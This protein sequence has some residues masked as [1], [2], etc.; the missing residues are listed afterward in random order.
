VLRDADGPV[1]AGLLDAAWADERQR[2]RALA[3]LVADGLAEQV[4]GGG[5]ALPR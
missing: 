1:P 3:S 2:V 5:Y 4:P